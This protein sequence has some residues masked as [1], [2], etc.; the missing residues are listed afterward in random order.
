MELYHWSI[1]HLKILLWQDR[2]EETENSSNIP[3]QGIEPRS[4]AL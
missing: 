2:T 1:H 4:P 3:N